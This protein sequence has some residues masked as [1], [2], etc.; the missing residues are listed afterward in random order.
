MQRRDLLRSVVAGLGGTAALGFS[1]P[2]AALAAVRAP[3]QTGPSPYGP[4]HSADAN[5]VMLPSRFAS[6]VIARTGRKVSGTS[7]TWHGAPD[8]GGCFADG[9]GWIYVS[10]SELPDGNGGVSAIR[11]ASSGR[12]TS[13]YRILRGTTLNCAGG[14]MPWRTW[15]SCE[16]VDRGYV[17]ET[18]PWGKKAAVKRPAMGRFRHEAAAAD[19]DRKVI[20]LTEDEPDGCFYRFK[21]TTW[22]NLSSGRLQVLASRSGTPIWATVPDPAA[23]T[24]RTRNQVAGARR[25]NGGEGCYYAHGICYFTTKG[26]NRVWA[27]DAVRHTMAIAYDDDRT[28]AAPLTGVDNITG[29]ASGDLY[30]AEDGGNLDVCIVTPDGVVATFLRVTGQAKSELAGLAFSPD[31][32]RLYVSSPRGRTGRNSGGITYEIRGP[33]RRTA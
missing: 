32:K 29:T 11:F 4:L 23:R 6:R 3:A 15:L 12:I 9:A 16:E 25:F 18:D 20:Y 1:V 28:S 7:L 14:V 22:G 33:F 5:G 26:D 31:G 17:F 21:P 27:Y 13:A 2:S 24:T 30:V 8:G 10:N 19:P